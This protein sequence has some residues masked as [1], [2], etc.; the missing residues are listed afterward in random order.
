[1]G[2][3]LG[4]DIERGVLAVRAVQLE[5]QGAADL[6]SPLHHGQR[7]QSRPPRRSHVAL[8]HQLTPTGKHLPDKTIIQPI[9]R[10]CWP[11]LE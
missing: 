9:R 2:G 10:L 6:C 11:Y 7:T 3:G 1:M 4:E 5:Q 8:R